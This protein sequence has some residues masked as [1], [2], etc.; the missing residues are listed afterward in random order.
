MDK[1]GSGGGVWE[2]KGGLEGL[3]IQICYIGCILV[4]I[5]IGSIEKLVVS[6]VRRQP[7]MGTLRN[8][9]TK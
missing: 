3:E 8:F 9:N 7:R 6:R 4:I 2:G 1:I 5:K